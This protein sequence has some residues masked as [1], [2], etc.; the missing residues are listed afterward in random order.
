M[1]FYLS[2]VLLSFTF[3]GCAHSPIPS[4]DPAALTSPTN[5]RLEEL[6]KKAMNS[7]IDLQKTTPDSDYLSG[8]WNQYFCVSGIVKLANQSLLISR[9]PDRIES[10]SIFT[11]TTIINILIS[12][13]R[14]RIADMPPALRESIN[15]SLNNFD[16][17]Y[18]QGA[19]HF[20]PE[21][22][23]VGNDKKI[24]RMHRPVFKLEGELFNLKLDN[25]AFVPSD[26]DTSAAVVM[27]LFKMGKLQPKTESEYTQKL[28]S[29]LD[30][31]RLPYQGNIARGEINT[32]A[33]L[34]WF[35]DDPSLL[36]AIGNPPLINAL[37]A[38]ENG[39]RL[40]QLNDVDCVVNANILRSLSLTNNQSLKGYAPACDLVNKN[41][42]KLEHKD[43]G[44]YYPNSM[45]LYFVTSAAIADGVQ[46]L[47]PSAEKMIEVILKTQSSFDGSWKNETNLV[48]TLT[49]E[50][51]TQT[52]LYALSSILD[53]QQTHPHLI[54]DQVISAFQKGLLY[55]MSNVEEGNQLIHFKDGLFFSAFP[56]LRD[57]TAWKS[58]PLT[59]ALALKVFQQAQTF[60]RLK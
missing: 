33:Y 23:I 12:A 34:T 56:I 54:S 31:K 44:I 22:D 48:Q 15:L 47:N 25:I 35:I 10:P 32:G 60:P 57:S 4:R 45:Y 9:T 58:Q 24:Y 21:R 18:D 36:S 6:T 55:V 28:L 3:L 20:F 8:D 19:Y 11:N 37:T 46:C 7:V 5:A 26:S 29:Y 14:N 40:P 51:K 27:T 59:T 38:P 50:D 13:Y 52:T 49:N 42:L 2:S 1:K 17:Y 16:K 41:I 53:L 39:Q 30:Q 43:C